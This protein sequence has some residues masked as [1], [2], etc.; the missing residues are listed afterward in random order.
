M[1]INTI[2]E[3]RNFSK[4]EA[5]AFIDHADETRLVRPDVA[6]Y[7]TGYKFDGDKL[8]KNGEARNPKDNYIPRLQS[9]ELFPKM[10]AALELF[11]PTVLEAKN[12]KEE[13][14]VMKL[15]EPIYKVQ[16]A[17]SREWREVEVDFFMARNDV[18]YTALLQDF[19]GFIA[20]FEEVRKYALANSKQ[21][22]P[23][24]EH[25]AAIF[26]DFD[27]KTDWFSFI[28]ED[29]LTL[30]AGF[31]SKFKGVPVNLTPWKKLFWDTHKEKRAE[32]RQSF[33]S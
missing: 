23:V 6:A 12:P 27:H 14:R 24:A 4:E 19:A 15:V 30:G 10:V 33:A 22:K 20:V 7:L 5:Q 31:E 11:L 2:R 32:F 21:E 9:L 17:V 1:N 8:V 28:L 29:I 18:V 3:P 25:Y 26:K 13:V 16:C